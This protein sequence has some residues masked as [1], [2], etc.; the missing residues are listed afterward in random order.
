VVRNPD[1][2]RHLH[3]CGGPAKLGFIGLAFQ[4]KHEPCGLKPARLIAQIRL[5]HTGE[6]AILYLARPVIDDAGAHQEI[7][8]MVVR[9]I[10]ESGEVIVDLNYT[11]CEMAA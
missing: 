3:Y 11:Q 4:L 10:G 6:S 2:L 1:E 9:G 8:L 7:V 5:P